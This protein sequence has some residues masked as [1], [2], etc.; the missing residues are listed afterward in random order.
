MLKR[1]DELKADGL[2]SFR[3]IKAHE[4]KRP[5]TQ[6]DAVLADAQWVRTQL[7]LLTTVKMAEDFVQEKKWKVCMA[8]TVADWVVQ[9]HAASP[10][11]RASLCVKRSA[12]ICTSCA[13]KANVKLPNQRWTLTLTRSVINF[14]SN[15]LKRTRWTMYHTTFKAPITPVLTQIH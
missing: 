14:N 1:V 6:W 2:W 5:R 8:K 10:Q 13:C 9:W 3:Q 12:L 7:F 4:V 11:A 15:S